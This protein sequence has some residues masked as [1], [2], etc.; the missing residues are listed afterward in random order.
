MATFEDNAVVTAGGLNNIAVD[1]GHTT[2]SLFSD[3]PFGVDELNR[4]TAD[5]VG[6]GVL[7]TG[8]RC[9]PKLDNGKV[10]IQSGV[11]V[12]GSGAKIRIESPVEVAAAKGDYI[13]AFNDVTT[14][15]ASI[16]TSADKP[17]TG[18]FVMLAQLDSAG[19]VVDER[20]LSVA[21]A[22]STADFSVQTFTDTVILSSDR[23]ETGEFCYAH[24]EI[25]LATTLLKRLVGFRVPNLRLSS[26]A[27]RRD[28]NCFYDFTN[29]NAH[30]VTSYVP[31]GYFNVVYVFE[32]DGSTLK[33]AITDAVNFNNKPG[34]EFRIEVDMI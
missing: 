6:K 4:I 17:T 2:F 24:G 20:I 23:Y 12:F 32:L 15:K 10:Y 29:N 9:E 31:A 8:N 33:W 16:I 25:E 11:I 30:T 5:L 19:T 27:P 14:G 7:T 18:D 13:Y 3:E 21:K 28:F 26:Y 1:L 22:L 34:E